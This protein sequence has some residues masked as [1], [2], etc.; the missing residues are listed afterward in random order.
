MTGNEW[1]RVFEPRPYARIRVVCF[2][3]AGGNA[4]FF[5]AWPARLPDY[6]EMH[7]VQYPGRIDRVGEPLLR[8]MD[9]MAERAAAA[10]API[11]R[12]GPV[13]LFGH[14]LG[15]AVAYEVARR[16]EA[17]PGTAA[18]TLIVSGRP[19]P[20]RQRGGSVHLADDATLWAELASLGGTGDE[21]L[22][23]PALRELVLPVLRADYQVAETY[24]P[25]PAAPL[26]TPV[27]AYRGDLDPKVTDEEAMAWADCTSGEFR[28]RVFPGDHFYLIPKEA[29]VVGEI[30]RTAALPV[31][32]AGGGP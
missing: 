28:S 15:A 1:L 31:S 18:A 24:Q 17:G 5:R 25:G 29:E 3:H 4:A 21:V 6:I 9:D 20:H 14:S 27:H 11:T 13:V 16:L 8:R 30:V 32:W 23:H 26:T 12:T 22:E 10:I 7:A 2:P 19:A